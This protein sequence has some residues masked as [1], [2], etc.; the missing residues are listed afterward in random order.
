MLPPDDPTLFYGRQDAQAF[1]RQNLVGAD[2]QHLIIVLGRSGIGKTALLHH[3]AYIVDE[4]YHPV[5]IDLVGSPHASIPQVIT[6][7]ATAIVTHMESVGASTYRIP[8]FPEPIETDNAWL[9]WF[10]D[11]F[12]DVAVTAIRRDNFLLLLLDDLHLFF[13]ATDNNSLSEDFITYLGSL[14]TS[15]DRLDIVGGVDIRFEHQLMQHP[16]TQNINLHWRLETLN[17]DAVHQ[18]ITEPIQG[19]YTLTPDALDRIKFLCGGHPFLLHSVCRL[20]YRFHEE[21]NVTTINADM[22]EYIYEPAL[23]ETSDTM[24]AFW[25]GASQQ[26]VL[27][28]RAL[29]END[30][31]VPSSIQ[32]LLAWSQDHGFGLNQTQLVARLREIEYETLVRTNEAGEYYFCSGLEADWLAN[33][34]TELPNLTPNRFPNTSNRIGLIAI[35]VAVVVIVIG[36]LIFQSASDTEPTQDALPTTTLEVNIDATRQAEQAS[37]TPLP[38]PVTVTPPPVEVPSWLSAP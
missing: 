33:Q 24:Q 8:D 13:Q 6:T 19:T 11:D 37:P 15:Y 29:L 28:L 2:N 14:L 20:V 34:I 31:H 18:L 3:V 10:K 38:P 9:R 12:L 36:F 35:G 30:P 1:L 16:P 32:A 22:L 5:Y 23:I 17:D 4:R 27:V 7:I 21:R 25:D 26:M